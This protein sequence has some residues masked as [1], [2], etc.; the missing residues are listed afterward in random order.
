MEDARK[1]PL[2]ELAR[3]RGPVAAGHL[4]TAVDHLLLAAGVDAQAC[5]PLLAAHIRAAN[6]RHEE[7]LVVGVELDLEKVLQAVLLA[8]GSSSTTH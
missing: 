7:L 4:E 6:G 3:Q 8:K 5:I 1:Q 2:L